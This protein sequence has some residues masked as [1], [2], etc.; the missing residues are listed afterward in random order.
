MVAGRRMFDIA[1]AWGGHPPGG[2]P[3]FIVTHDPPQG[4]LKEGSP[5][6]FVTDGYDV[7][8]GAPLTPFL[9]FFAYVWVLWAAKSL[10]AR[11]YRPSTAPD[12]GLTTTVIV[13]VYRT[14]QMGVMMLR[15]ESDLA[16]LKAQAAR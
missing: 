9:A 10:A 1:H 11:R 7:L 3:C 14:N 13:P 5:F 4:W 8:R 2:G 15:G 6:T 12:A 16:A